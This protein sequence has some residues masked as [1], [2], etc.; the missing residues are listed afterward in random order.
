MTQRGFPKGDF[1]IIRK[2]T[3]IINV[4]KGQKEIGHVIITND[5]E[6]HVMKLSII[7]DSQ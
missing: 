1:F 4:I 7:T 5:A 3:A 2:S 6:R